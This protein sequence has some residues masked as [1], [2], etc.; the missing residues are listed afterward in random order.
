MN[1]KIAQNKNEQQRQQQPT[2][3]EGSSSSDE[4]GR[5]NTPTGKV[6]RPVGAAGPERYGVGKCIGM[7]PARHGKTNL[8]SRKACT[9]T[10]GIAGE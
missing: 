2:G 3:I 10:T 8:A 4:A 5:K 9:G 7:R 1:K 6:L